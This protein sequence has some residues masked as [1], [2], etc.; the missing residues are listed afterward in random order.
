MCK[1]F[2]LC[3]SV[4]G[5]FFSLAFGLHCIHTQIYVCSACPITWLRC[6]LHSTTR[7]KSMAHLFFHFG[8][9]SSGTVTVLHCE[10]IRG[11]THIMFWI[12]SA[13]YSYSSFF[14]HRN[15]IFL[16]FFYSYGYYKK[17]NQLKIKKNRPRKKSQSKTKRL[18]KGNLELRSNIPVT[19][20]LDLIFPL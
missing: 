9:C 5:A 20:S 15:L 19:E 7:M 12:K 1:L 13:K 6:H 17:K 18:D 10:R 3:D 4:I 14:H 16:K 11:K 2:P 8:Y